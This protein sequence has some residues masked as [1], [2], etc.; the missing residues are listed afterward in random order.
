MEGYDLGYKEG[1]SKGFEDGKN[2]QSKKLKEEQ[3]EK[4]LKGFSLSLEELHNVAVQIHDKYSDVV[5]EISLKLVNAKTYEMA[6][7]VEESIYNMNKREMIGFFMKLEDSFSDILTINILSIGNHTSIS[8]LIVD[9]FIL[10]HVR[11]QE[12]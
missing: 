10:K 6:V 9:G 8:S 1:E 3:E 5:S 11:Q 7:H 4:V 2:V 12:T